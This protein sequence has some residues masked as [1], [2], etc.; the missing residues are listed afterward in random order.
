MRGMSLRSSLVGALAMC[1]VLVACG[2]SHGDEIIDQANDSA[3]PGGAWSIAGGTPMGQEFRPDLGRLDFV[4][5]YIWSYDISAPGT[6]VVDV[7]LDSPSGALLGTSL[8]VEV[9]VGEFR[10]VRLGFPETVLLT[11][12]TRYVLEPRDVSASG[13][14]LGDTSDL[15]A[16]GRFYY[17]GMFEPL[18][19]AWFREGYYSTGM[20]EMPDTWGGIKSLFR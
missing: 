3:V 12:G 10:P 19:D 5:L 8:P 14:F 16:G 7:R 17:S 20:G 1:V 9:P 4:D 6:L 13:L 18:Y 11:P 2:A 15:Y